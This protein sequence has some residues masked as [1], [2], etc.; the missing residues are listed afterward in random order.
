MR[1][2]IYIFVIISLSLTINGQLK[3]KSLGFEIEKQTVSA[4]PNKNGAADF[5]EEVAMLNEKGVNAALTENDYRKANDFFRQAAGL[6]AGCFVCRYNL[7]KSFL[8]LENY[9]EAIEILNKLVAEKPDY[10]NAYSILGN[11]LYRKNRFDESISAYQKSLAIEPDNAIALCSLAVSQYASGKYE[12]ALQNFNASIKANPE[13]P[14]AYSNR[15]VTLHILGRNKEAL[16]D[17]RRAQ[18]LDPNAA[19]IENNIG[20]TLSQTGKRK[21]AHKC[22][23]KALALNPDYDAARFNLAISFLERN[24]RQ[25]ADIQLRLLEKINFEMAE[26]LRKQFWKKYVINADDLKKA[27]N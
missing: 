20:V 9:D 2:I 19:E 16:A 22:F 4:D 3:T 21:E 10:A 11:A 26:Q 1:H 17:F 12:Q 23:E 18:V 13:L 24:D 8:E 7:G 14:E 5:S 6:D 15:G 25:Q 27:L